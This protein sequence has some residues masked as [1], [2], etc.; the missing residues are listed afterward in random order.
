[1][2]NYNFVLILLTNLELQL[3]TCKPL[4]S[5]VE[6][7]NIVKR[8]G[9]IVTTGKLPIGCGRS[10]QL[11]VISFQLI[12]NRFTDRPAMGKL[13]IKSDKHIVT[14]CRPIDQECLKA[15]YNRQSFEHR[16]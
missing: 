13:K 3:V 4:E 14:V 2:P 12:R 16:A 9:V 10:L 7:V 1:M 11:N 5:F 8:S 6:L 15:N